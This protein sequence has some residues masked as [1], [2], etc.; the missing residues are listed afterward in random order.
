M[1]RLKRSEV[2]SRDLYEGYLTEHGSSVNCARGDEFP[3]FVFTCDGVKHAVE[4]TELHEYLDDGLSQGDSREA[5]ERPIIEICN[6]LEKQLAPTL[7]R[8]V[9]VCISFPLTKGELNSL[10]RSIL[11]YVNRD[12]EEREPLFGRDD[13]WL[14][15]SADDNPGIEPILIPSASSTVPGSKKTS[16]NI[17]ASID[18]AVG[19]ILSD[20]LPRF[21]ALGYFHEKVL[22]IYSN[23]SRCS[24]EHI[25]RSLCKNKEVSRIL[26]K[27]FLLNPW[28]DLRDTVD[29]KVLNEITL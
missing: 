18:Y 10:R 13:C 21:K 25:Q 7:D 23:D 16:A 20:K 4:V 3:D 9:C 27:A 6:N 12:I 26:T 1:K 5:F 14:E 17:Q 8:F 22:M 15:S 24:L 28:H 19:R 11:S 29:S 2:I